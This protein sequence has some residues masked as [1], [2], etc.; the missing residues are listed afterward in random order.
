MQNQN[1]YEAHRY[2]SIFAGEQIFILSD[3]D[4]N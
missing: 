4:D 3:A 2:F 1:K